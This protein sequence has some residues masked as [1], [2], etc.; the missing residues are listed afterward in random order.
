MALLRNNF[1]DNDPFR[2]KTTDV[3]S[4][5][6]QGIG[7]SPFDAPAPSRTVTATQIKPVTF[8]ASQAAALAAEPA[9]AP[10]TRAT[11]P[12][13]A[14]APAAAPAPAP[15]AP[16]PTRGIA[17]TTAGLLAPAEEKP[18]DIEETEL[19]KASQKATLEQLAGEAPGFEAQ[20]TIG[21][22]QLK[23]A[24]TQRAKSIRE[25]LVGAGF[26]DTGKFLEEGIL[27]PAQQT[28]AER[29]E[30]ERGLIA[31]RAS[32]AREQVIQGQAAATNLINLLQSGKLT[33]E[34]LASQKDLLSLSLTSAENIALL[35]V[36]GQ[37]E[38]ATLND[39][40][41][42]GRLVLANDFAA[43]EARLKE[44]HALAIQNND[45]EQAEKIAKLVGTLD[46][47]KISKA[48][49]YTLAL[50]NAN[51]AWKTTAQLTDIAAANAAQ[52]LDI[53]ADQAAQDKDIIAMEN[54]ASLQ[55]KLKIKMQ[56][57]AF[58][59]DEKMTFLDAEIAEAKAVGDFGREKELLTFKAAIQFEQTTNKQ[60]H[61]IAMAELDATIQENLDNNNFENAK[62]LEKLKFDN[63]WLMHVD[64]YE[65]QKL[66]I[67]LKEAGVDMQE[68]EQ[69]YLFITAEILAGRL[70][71]DAAIQFLAKNLPEGVEYKPP[72]PKATQNALEEDFL[73]QQMQWAL[74]QVGGIDGVGKFDPDTGQF[75]GLKDEFAQQ[76]NDHLNFTLYDTIEGPDAQT[77]T[78]LL[79]GTKSISFFSGK[80]ASDPIYLA[81]LDSNKTKAFAHDKTEV[82]FGSSSR[83]I[84]TNM[85]SIGGF[86]KKN[87][88]L[89]Q[90][91]AKKTQ[92]KAGD[93]WKLYKITNVLTGKSFWISTEFS[94]SSVNNSFENEES[95]T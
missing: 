26:R 61:D 73:A 9:P 72:D 56:T 51:N 84:F 80:D 30:F 8:D 41:T 17:P 18:F 31:D 42:T 37:K 11:T 93:D 63:E 55:A 62:A 52:V 13:P 87:G 34:E 66:E 67:T 22:E 70:N 14:A 10:A 50:Q 94:S 16:A 19:F 57:Q 82:G 23:A 88:V 44:D 33:Q 47:L 2:K 20:A 24:Q 58:G 5:V 7:D 4:G 43:I 27:A 21:R 49:E 69:E 65:I 32:K 64:N 60:G 36:E 76:W 35:N 3:F 85:P 68:L 48:A 75:I 15:A 1:L 45:F 25:G 90:L 28:F 79:D 92:D 83:I 74:T 77:I 53:A 54:I 39:K 6:A 78:A 59:H 95:R 29:S 46:L 71:P 86:L 12:A 91:S 81:L 40:L 89:Y 38:L